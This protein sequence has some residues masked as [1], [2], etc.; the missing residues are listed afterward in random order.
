MSTLFRVKAGEKSFK[1]IPKDN[2]RI[3]FIISLKTKGRLKE[4]FSIS[5]F[6]LIFKA[7]DLASLLLYALEK[8]CFKVLYLFLLYCALFNQQINF[9][10]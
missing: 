9:Y 7:G 10:F 8:N 4:K 5:S 3:L 6:D 1:G 2:F